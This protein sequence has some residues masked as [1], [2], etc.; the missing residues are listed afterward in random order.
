MAILSPDDTVTAVVAITY[1]TPVRKTIIFNKFRYLL[2]GYLQRIKTKYVWLRDM[3]EDLC[4][5][6]HSTKIS[7]EC[8]PPPG[9][10][11]GGNGQW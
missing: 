7:Q 4:H 2:T 9:G 11:R 3:S 6:Q 1:F 5:L 8:F 10:T